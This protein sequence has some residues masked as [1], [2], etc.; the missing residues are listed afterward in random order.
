MLLV[1]FTLIVVF[2]AV[3]GSVWAQ[4]VEKININAATAEELVN[5]EKVGSKIAAR[6]VEYRE[7]KGTFEK[8]E[9]IMKVKGIGQK[10]FEINKDRIIVE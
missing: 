6:I 9:D 1:V 8:P 10:I 2:I 4:E 7:A 5:L 3:N